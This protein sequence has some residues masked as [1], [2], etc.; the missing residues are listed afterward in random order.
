MDSQ[1]FAKKLLPAPTKYNPTLSLAEISKLRNVPK[2]LEKNEP[3]A[4][5]EKP[6]RAP[7]D[8]MQDVHHDVI[9]ARSMRTVFGKEKKVSNVE[10]TTAR[11][12]KWPACNHYK[13]EPQFDKLGAPP[14]QLRRNRM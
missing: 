4:P 6:T 3:R 10:K 12:K 14:L 1:T 5:A 8:K 7:G 11:V 9:R 2:K 13:W